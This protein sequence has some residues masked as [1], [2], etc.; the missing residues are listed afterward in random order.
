KEKKQLISFLLS[1]KSSSY[2]I[3]KTTFDE[4]K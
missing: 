1:Y 4:L 3:I 2:Y